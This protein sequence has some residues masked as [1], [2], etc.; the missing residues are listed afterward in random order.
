M[1]LIGLTEGKAETL[2]SWLPNENF[3]LMWGSMVYEWPVTVG[4]IMA[5][6]EQPDVCSYYLMEL[7]VELGFIE[8]QKT[9]THEYRL[10]RV[11]VSKAARGRGIGKILVEKAL[12]Q[13]NILDPN[14]ERVTLAVFA[15]NKSAYHCYQSCGFSEISGEPNFRQVGDEKWTLLHMEK[16]V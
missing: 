1:Q 11:I 8:I 15:Q 2:L 5:R 16:C 13:I 7:E 10:C 12:E 14:V 3:A 9:K 6:Q 4:Q